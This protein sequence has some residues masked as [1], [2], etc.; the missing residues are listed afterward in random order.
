MTTTNQDVMK[1]D[2]AIQKI[3]IQQYEDIRQSGLTNMFNFTN[4]VYIAKKMGFNELYD[5]IAAGTQ[6][7]DME[8]Y[9]SILCNFGKLMKKH[10]IKQ[11]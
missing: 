8:S 3:I 5:F 2:D 11:N 10:N 6:G 4:V 7:Q 1:L 9:R